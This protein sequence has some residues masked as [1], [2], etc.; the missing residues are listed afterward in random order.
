VVHGGSNPSSDGWG[1]GRQRS[2]GGWVGLGMGGSR[3]SP[4]IGRARPV[5]SGGWWQL[6]TEGG[7]SGGPRSGS[8]VR[9]TKE[10]VARA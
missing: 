7:R 10:R 5:A 1:G 6:P 2:G 4:G 8:R 9:C 3:W